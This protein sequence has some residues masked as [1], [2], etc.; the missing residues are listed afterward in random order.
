MFIKAKE[1]SKNTCPSVVARGMKEEGLPEGVDGEHITIWVTI[2][3]IDV[4]LNVWEK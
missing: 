4:N 1:M 2:E 3:V